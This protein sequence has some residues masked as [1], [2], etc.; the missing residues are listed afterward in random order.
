MQQVLE[1]IEYR[2]NLTATGQLIQA[3]S[4]LLHAGVGVDITHVHGLC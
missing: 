3:A 2:L 1:L 4:D